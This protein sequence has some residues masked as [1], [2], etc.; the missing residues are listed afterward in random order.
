[1]LHAQYEEASGR[2]LVRALCSGGLFTLKG[3]PRADQNRKY[4]VTTVRH[5]ISIDDYQSGSKGSST[6]YANTFTVIAS[7]IPYRPA[8]ITPNPIVQGPQ[9]ALVVGPAGDEIYTD[10]HARVKLQFHWDRYGK[11]NQDSSCWVRVSQL[12]AG[13]TWGGIHI[14]RMGQEVIVEFLEGDPDRPIIVGRVYN[15]EQTP[16]Y[17]LPANKTQSG[18]KSRSSQGGGPANFNEIRMEDKKGEEQL[19]IHAEK[20]QDNIVENDETTSVGHDR[21]EG[22]GHDETIKIGNNRTETVGVNETIAI[23]NNR[24]EL[25]GVNET[26][27]IGANRNK[28]VGASETVSVALQRTHTVGIN[29]TIGVGAAQEIG[30]GA[31]QAVAIGAYQTVN[32]GAYQSINVGANQSTDVGAN[33][34]VSVGANQTISVTGNQSESVTGNA[35][36]NVKGNDSL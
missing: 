23:G 30:I 29:E 4:M 34:S 33:Q 27:T 11:K 36:K 32:V 2:S 26:I 35:S 21:S 18:I 17:A 20:N 5:T 15:G 9:T 13:K 28:S 16:P 3:Y 24:T 8:R 1:E 19:Y 14:P 7:D 25:V 12:W 22:V 31:F 10:E 6:D